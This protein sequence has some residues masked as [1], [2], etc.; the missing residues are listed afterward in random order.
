[1]LAETVILDDVNTRLLAKPRSKKCAEFTACEAAM[2]TIGTPI[3]VVRAPGDALQLNKHGGL[4]AQDR[5]GDRLLI[6]RKIPT[7]ATYAN[8][9][10]R[11]H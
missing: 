11:L 10:G 6:W 5:N 4:G 8:W 7:I 9:V 3:P 2:G 1:M